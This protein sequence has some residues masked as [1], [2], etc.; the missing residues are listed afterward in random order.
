MYASDN[1]AVILPSN[2]YCYN[3]AWFEK[4]QDYIIQALSALEK[5]QAIANKVAI[6]NRTISVRSN[7][8]HVPYVSHMFK[9]A[10]ISV[11]GICP[12]PSTKA[13]G[14]YRKMLVYTIRQHKSCWSVVTYMYHV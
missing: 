6:K 11:C 5:K 8:I 10:V 3:K 1:M 14:R 2:K 7:I 12:R 4:E 13:K 9:F